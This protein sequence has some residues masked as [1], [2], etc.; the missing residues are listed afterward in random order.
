GAQT[1]SGFNCDLS[2]VSAWPGAGA[3]FAVFG[4]ALDG[5]DLAVA[6]NAHRYILTE[7]LAGD[8]SRADSQRGSSDHRIDSS[9]SGRA[10][11]A[12]VERAF[13]QGRSAD[14]RPDDMAELQSDRRY[15]QR[16]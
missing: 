13:R 4:G 8:A 12:G 11:C 3:E 6:L 15:R 1:Y 9:N 14:R 5:A 7:Q 2:A 16:D 10:G